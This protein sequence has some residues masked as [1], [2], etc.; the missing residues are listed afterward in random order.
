MTTEAIC[1]LMDT[2]RFGAYAIDREQRLLFWNRGAEEILGHGRQEVL[3]RRCC[4]VLGALL[5]GARGPGC[6]GECPSLRQFRLGL[7]P[8]VFQLRL[9]C[10]WGERKQVRVIPIAVADPRMGEPVLF[11]LFHELPGEGE[12]PLLPLGAPEALVGA[13]RGHGAGMD[14][15][16]ESGAESGVNAG[17]A[18]GG[19]PVTRRELEVLRLLSLGRDTQQIAGELKLSHHTVL[20]HI[21]NSRRKLQAPTRMDAV[22]TAMRLGFL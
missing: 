20:N 3:G 1:N 11:H 21:R 10:L 7:I 2:S 6:A 4:E 14:S 22:L 17:V 15:D 9:L 18:A 16:A 13:G 19:Q 5:P 8:S 12:T